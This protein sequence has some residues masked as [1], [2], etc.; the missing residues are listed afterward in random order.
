MVEKGDR[1]RSLC[2]HMLIHALERIVSGFLLVL[3]FKRE[4]CQL[5]NLFSPFSNQQH[6]HTYAGRCLKL[7]D[8]SIHEKHH[9]DFV[10][11][12]LVNRACEVEQI[13]NIRK[14]RQL[15]QIDV[16]FQPSGYL[17]L[18]PSNYLYKNQSSNQY[19]GLFLPTFVCI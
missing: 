19:S 16:F 7:E 15:Y 3:H 2:R 10:C 4:S 5:A 6:T 13:S 1:G 17:F 8:L 11:C 9:F 12:A 14:V 18:L